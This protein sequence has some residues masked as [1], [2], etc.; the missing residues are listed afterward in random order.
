MSK[1]GDIRTAIL[2]TQA[3]WDATHHDGISREGAESVLINGN[4]YTAQYNS[5]RGRREWKTGEDGCILITG[6]RG[7]KYR[8]KRP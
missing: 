5:P 1:R 3:H 6:P 4:W 8:I 7:G 2:K